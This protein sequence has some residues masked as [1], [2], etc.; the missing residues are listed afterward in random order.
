[1]P[2]EN[3]L[4]QITED[5]PDPASLLDL[6]SPF[7]FLFMI[8]FSIFILN[9]IKSFCTFSNLIP[10]QNQEKYSLPQ[11]VVNEPT[12]SI[13]VEGFTPEEIELINMT[14]N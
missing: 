2:C 12:E 5:P 6:M 11:I 1:M 13:D 14:L 9:I 3:A 10:C 7:I 8:T 4:V